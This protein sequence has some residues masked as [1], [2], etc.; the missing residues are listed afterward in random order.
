MKKAH[1][2]GRVTA[3]EITPNNGCSYPAEFAGVCEG[4]WRRVLGDPAGLTQFGVNLVTLEPGAWSA[5]RHWHSHEDEFVFVLEGEATL[6]TDRG[7]ET[8]KAGEA[9]GFP[10][11]RA[12]GHHL[13]NRSD[14]E[15]RYLEIGTRSEVDQVSY[16][17]IDLFLTQSNG[18]YKFVNL[19]GKPYGDAT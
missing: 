11:G 19:R 16:P 15:L 14:R 18:R 8:L 10:A 9:A 2:D 12:N 6:V 4:R 3:S 7:E 17:D 13:I 5:Q 1:Y